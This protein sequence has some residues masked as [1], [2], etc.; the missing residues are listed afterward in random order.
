M[1]RVTVGRV[2]SGLLVLTGLGA[3]ALAGYHFRQAATVN[4]SDCT[5]DN[6]DCAGNRDLATG[7]RWLT[8][9]ILLLVT[10]LITVWIVVRRRSTRSSPPTDGSA[11]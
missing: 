6:F 3:A 8:L 11:G 4:G 2:W 7:L 1:F 10:A 5:F 9:L